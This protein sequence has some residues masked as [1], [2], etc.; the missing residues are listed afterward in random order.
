M[1]TLELTQA[2]FQSTVE[3]EGIVLV[4]VW[5]DWCTPCKSFA[6]TYEA[7]SAAAGNEDIVFGKV[8]SDAEQPLAGALEIQ[9]IPTVMAFR[10]GVLVFRNSGVLSAEQ[11]DHVIKAVR[12]LDMDEVRRQI[13]EQSTEAEG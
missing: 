2:N 5:A 3:G 4:D 1:A 11:L 12:D 10:D 8:D 9:A 7:A 13:A 6:P